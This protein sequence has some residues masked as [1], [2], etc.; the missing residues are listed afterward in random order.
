MLAIKIFNDKIDEKLINHI[1][2]SGIEEYGIE[3]ALYGSNN[4]YSFGDAVNNLLSKIQTE[5][6]IHHTD[7]KYISLEALSRK[8]KKCIEV[9]EREA[10]QCEKMNIK[11]TVI[12]LSTNEKLSPKNKNPII[13]LD[14]IMNSLEQYKNYNLTP[15]LENTFED[16]QWHSIF[17]DEVVKRNLQE[18]IGMTLDIGHVKVWGKKNL[19]EWTTLIN[20]LYHYNYKTHFH[21]HANDGKGDLHMPLFHPAMIN[22]IEPSEYC[23]DGVLKWLNK[24]MEVHKNSLFTLESSFEDASNSLAFIKWQQ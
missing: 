18:Y 24:T 10:K 22:E 20:K 6:K 19:D 2:N 12:H 8:D 16:Y 23:K 14:S 4:N 9:L 3:T 1:I 7:H 5:Y 15:L 17:W 11:N 13:V 21:I